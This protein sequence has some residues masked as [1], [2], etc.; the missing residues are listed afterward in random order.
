MRAMPS[1]T[2]RTVTDFG[3]FGLVPE[4]RDLLLEN[5]GDFCGADIHQ[6]TSFI[7]VRISEFKFGLERGVDHA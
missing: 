5:G 6:P 7:R 2:E 1:P 4:I 3:D